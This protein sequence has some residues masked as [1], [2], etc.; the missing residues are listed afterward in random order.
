MLF[1]SQAGR[2]SPRLPLG[3]ALTSLCLLPACW[4]FWAHTGHPI[5]SALARPRLNTLA[6]WCVV[7]F[8]FLFVVLFLQPPPA[9]PKG[10]R[11]SLEPPSASFPRR[12]KV[13]APASAAL[14][15]APPLSSASGPRSD[16]PDAAL[17]FLSPLL[18]LGRP[19]S[20]SLLPPAPRAAAPLSIILIN[21]SS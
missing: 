15:A 10:S 7:L 18:R 8:V 12:A 16:S 13:S 19:G 2:N 14:G 11:L 20:S 1:F 21:Y 6:L 17:D 4:P 9:V 3:T 5:L